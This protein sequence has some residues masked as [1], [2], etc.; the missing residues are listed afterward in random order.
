MGGGIKCP[1]VSAYLNKLCFIQVTDYSSAAKRRKDRF[2]WIEAYKWQKDVC[3]ILLSKK[4]IR[5]A[6]GL[7]INFYRL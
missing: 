2:A 4:K 6:Y 5:T 1:L 7:C 3:N